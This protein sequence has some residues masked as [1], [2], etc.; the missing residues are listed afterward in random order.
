MKVKLGEKNE[1]NIKFSKNKIF[2]PILSQLL[3]KNYL[4][5]KITNFDGKAFSRTRA[6]LEKD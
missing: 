4:Y 2:E 1:R 6:Y 5:G 3:Q